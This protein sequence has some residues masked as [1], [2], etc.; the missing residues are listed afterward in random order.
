[1]LTSVDLAVEQCFYFFAKHTAF[2]SEALQ[3][4]L[5]N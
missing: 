5:M 3:V 4:T 2:F 1:M